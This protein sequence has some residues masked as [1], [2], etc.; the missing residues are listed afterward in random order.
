RGRPRLRPGTR[1]ACMLR[2]PAA[3]LAL[4]LMIAAVPRGAGAQAVESEVVESGAVE[5]GAADPRAAVERLF[6][7]EPIE[8][9]W[10]A[11]AFL[12]EIPAAEVERMVEDMTRRFGP[13]REI[14]AGADGLTVR[15]EGAEVPTRATLDRAGRIASLVFEAPI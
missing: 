2:R 11:P 14:A 12:A 8:R 3:I 6:G 9:D 13:L 15:L 10:F 5:S 4:A 1:E 7:G